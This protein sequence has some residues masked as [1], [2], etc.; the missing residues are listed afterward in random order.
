MTQVEAVVSSATRAALAPPEAGLTPSMLV[1]RAR[2]M[3]A[4]LR[5]QQEA[6]DQRGYY[7]DEIHQA[8]VRNGF[9]RILQPRLFGGYEMDF[10]TF[11]KV[12]MEISQGHPSSGWCFALSASHALLVASHWSEE[13]Q[14]ERSARRPEPACIL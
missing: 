13:A 5:E 9:Y 11:V 10:V 4:L 7:S 1:E 2:A 8:F 14:R 12:I 3:R 6:C